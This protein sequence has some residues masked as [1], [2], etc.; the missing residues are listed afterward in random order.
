MSS[1]HARR[2]APAGRALPIAGTP[3]SRLDALKTSLLIAVGAVVWAVGWFQ[4]AEKPAMDEQIAPLNVAVA[5]V[6][7]IGAGQALWFLNG[8]RAVAE[9]RRALLGESPAPVAAQAPAQGD[10]LFAGSQRFYHRLECAMV[11]D[12]GWAAMIRATHEA[13][14]R[15]PCGVC[16]P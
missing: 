5:G 13:A 7:V 9:R 6:V 2:L 4:V 1:I 14:G 3:W 15:V 11:V 12:R 16:K 10:E 8:R